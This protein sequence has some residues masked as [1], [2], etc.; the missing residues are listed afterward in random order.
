MH[1]ASK[2]FERVKKER[3][4]LPLYEDND[5]DA[6]LEA[7]ERMYTK[8]E[9]IFEERGITDRYLERLRM[10]NRVLSEKVENAR[11]G[12]RELTHFDLD[13]AITEVKDDVEDALI[14][15]V[16]AGEREECIKGLLAD[17]ELRYGY[18]F[19]KELSGPE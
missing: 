17:E 10:G 3:P 1:W 11:L 7:Y 15:L 14:Y 4:K 2:V 19:Q 6:R 13:Y 12:V 8:A 16:V 9:E 5:I 18:S